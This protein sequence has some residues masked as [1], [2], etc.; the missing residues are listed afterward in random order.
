VDFGGFRK[1]FVMH[2]RVG[3]IWSE[4]RE[5]LPNFAVFLG[6]IMKFHRFNR[7]RN[8]KTRSFSF[9]A[10]R[11]QPFTSLYHSGSSRILKMIQPWLNALDW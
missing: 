5:E 10:C 9:E 3:L 4:W 7:L 2:F 6:V 8:S 11:I 1:L